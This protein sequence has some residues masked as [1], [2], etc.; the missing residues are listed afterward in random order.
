MTAPNEA[1][2]LLRAKRPPALDRVLHQELAQA[3]EIQ[4]RS[5]CNDSITLLAAD[6]KG[7]DAMLLRNNEHAKGHAKPDLRCGPRKA[8]KSSPKQ[9]GLEDGSRMTDDFG[10]PM[11]DQVQEGSR[12]LALIAHQHGAYVVVHTPHALSHVLGT[13]NELIQQCHQ[14]RWG[15]VAKQGNDVWMATEDRLHAVVVASAIRPHRE[16]VLENR[17]SGFQSTLLHGPDQ[18]RHGLR[19]HLDPQQNDFAL[20]TRRVGDGCIQHLGVVLV[21]GDDHWSGAL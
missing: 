9:V 15:L 1:S 13:P 3:E 16:Q 4:A 17:A 19:T 10:I 21:D 6:V 12:Q 5:A 2:R 18:R 14:K 7:Y 11:L 20:P 8:A